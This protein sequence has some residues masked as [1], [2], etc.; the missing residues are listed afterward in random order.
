MPCNADHT[1]IKTDT[2]QPNILLFT[3]RGSD[4]KECLNTISYKA[5]SRYCIYY[6]LVFIYSQKQNRRK[7]F[8]I[9]TFNIANVDV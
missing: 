6:I 8:F 4:L 2:P 7:K 9:Q 5:V 1:R 3:K